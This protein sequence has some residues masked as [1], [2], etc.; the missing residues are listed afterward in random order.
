MWSFCFNCAN[1]EE[2]RV[3][4]RYSHLRA[5]IVAPC[6]PNSSIIGD[7]ATCES[8]LVMPVA[9]VAKSAERGVSCLEIRLLD[10]VI[11]S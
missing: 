3:P 9:T 5:Q 2:I 8:K 10:S 1:R 4:G 11:D 7:I 6:S